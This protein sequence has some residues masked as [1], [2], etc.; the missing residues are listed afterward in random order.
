MENICVC[1]I[2]D[3]VS[4]IKGFSADYW[5][6]EYP[7]FSRSDVMIEH[8]SGTIVGVHAVS[9]IKKILYIN[10][11]ISSEQVAEIYA[12]NYNEGLGQEPEQIQ[13]WKEKEVE[14][15]QAKL[16]LLKEGLL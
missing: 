15:S 8:V 9:D 16:I 11:D 7:S 10:E 2:W 4:D 5:L 14:L 1:S 6:R 12:K 3:K 13:K